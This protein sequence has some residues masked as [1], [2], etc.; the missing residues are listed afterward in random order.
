MNILHYGPNPPPG[1]QPLA[2]FP[3]GLDPAK[4]NQRLTARFGWVH[5]SGYSGSDCLFEMKLDL[6]IEFAAPF[7]KNQEA[8]PRQEFRDHEGVSVARPR[9][10]AIAKD[11][12]SQVANSV[13]SCFLPVWVRR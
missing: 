3:R 10:D 1:T 9:T 6:F 13:A 2:L 8:K 4:F 5:S 11:K 7:A 12:R